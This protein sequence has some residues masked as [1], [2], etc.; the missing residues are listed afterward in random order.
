[1]ALPGSTALPFVI[2]TEA[3][4]SGEICGFFPQKDDLWPTK[5]S[6]ASVEMAKGNGGDGLEQRVK[7]RVFL[8]VI[9]WPARGLVMLE[10]L[11]AVPY[12]LKGDRLELRT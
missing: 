7:D 3:Q 8:T 6:R 4:R 10:S 9:R 5:I 12:T 11:C 1:M 2:S